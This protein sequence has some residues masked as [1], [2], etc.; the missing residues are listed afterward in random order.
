MKTLK[1]LKKGCGTV[2]CANFD[3]DNGIMLCGQYIGA[4]CPTCQKLIKQ[5]EE[6]IEFIEKEIR[7][8]KHWEN[9]ENKDFIIVFNFLKERLI[10]KEKC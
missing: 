2:I 5:Q 1:E 3:Y 10:G 9:K 7:Y 4:L 8:W 6:I